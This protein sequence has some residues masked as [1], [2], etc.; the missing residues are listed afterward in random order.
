MNE[1]KEIINNTAF[2]VTAFMMMFIL[3]RETIHKNTEALI[4]IKITLESLKAKIE[5]EK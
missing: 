5:I 3:V 1:W 4:Q 2:P